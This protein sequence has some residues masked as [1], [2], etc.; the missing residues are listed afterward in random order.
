MAR[1]LD[2]AEDNNETP[3]QD[4]IIIPADINSELHQQ[5]NKIQTQL[6]KIQNEIDNGQIVRLQN[7]PPSGTDNKN[8]TLEYTDAYDDEYGYNYKWK[9]KQ[10]EQ[11]R[12]RMNEQYIY[13]PGIYI[14]NEMYTYAN[15][16]LGLDSP[17]GRYIIISQG[18]INKI[19]L[20]SLSG[21][22][23]NG[24]HDHDNNIKQFEAKT[25]TIHPNTYIEIESIN[26]VNYLTKIMGHITINSD[27]YPEE[28]YDII[29]PGNL[30]CHST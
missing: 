15:S 10:K 19:S 28:Q 11:E 24:I 12:E 27:S 23:I 29:G 20:K 8:K 1:Q 26:S 13:D 25:I 16:A 17:A 2:L 14:Y 22:R 6:N 7:P 4:T 3:H 30:T 18:T 5:L 21:V 9:W